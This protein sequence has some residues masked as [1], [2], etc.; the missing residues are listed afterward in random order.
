[1]K[2]HLEFSVRFLSKTLE[3]SIFVQLVALLFYTH[4]HEILFNFAVFQKRPHF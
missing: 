2:S 4:E 3:S 1:M